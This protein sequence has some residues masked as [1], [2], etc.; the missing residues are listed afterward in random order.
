MERKKKTPPPNPAVNVATP[1]SCCFRGAGRFLTAT[2]RAG[3]SCFNTTCFI[4]EP[5]QAV[6][7]P[8]NQGVKSA[9]ELDFVFCKWEGETGW[10]FICK[11]KGHR[12]PKDT[13]SRQT[14]LCAS[15]R[16][17]QT[18]PRFVFLIYFCIYPPGP[19]HRNQKRM[20]G[21][22]RKEGSSTAMPSCRRGGSHRS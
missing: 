12:T 10:I 5:I 22:H 7:V 4:S 2:H 3:G 20:G 15:S 1:T 8:S 11:H 18:Q 6:S 21:V 17:V 16:A 19:S 9:V 14:E 13:N